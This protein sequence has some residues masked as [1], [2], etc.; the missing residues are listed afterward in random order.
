MTQKQPFQEYPRP[1]LKRDSYFNLN[2]TWILNG[3]EII[4]PFPP[5]S[6][7]SGYKEKP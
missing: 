5:Q 3:K 1:Q 4:V 7:A 6:K 2:G